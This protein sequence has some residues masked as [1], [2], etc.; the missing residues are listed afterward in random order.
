MKK[1]LLYLFVLLCTVFAL[2]LFSCN[3]DSSDDDDSTS[4]S[5]SQ[6]TITI[7]YNANGGKTTV[8]QTTQ[9]A[10]SGENT[11]LKT[12]SE[13][14]LSRIGHTFVGWSRKSDTAAKES[15]SIIA[16]GTFYAD[17]TL[18]AVW[19]EKVY[20]YRPTGSI[21]SRDD[22]EFVFD[23]ETISHR[24]AHGF[25]LHKNKVISS[26]EFDE[27]NSLLYMKPLYVEEGEEKIENAEEM[28]SFFQSYY[29]DDWT[30]DIKGAILQYY[31]N[32]FARTEIYK[33]TYDS[34]A[35]KYVLERYF[36][37]KLP[38]A[39][40][41]DDCLYDASSIHIELTKTGS[42]SYDIPY[43]GYVD[44]S[45]NTF[46]G[47]LYRRDNVSNLDKAILTAVGTIAGTYSTS[48]TGTSGCTV[49]LTFDTFPSGFEYISAGKTMALT[50][51][52][53]T[54]TLFTKK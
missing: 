45:G 26:Y 47:T 28:V 48:G 44:F 5:S 34:S 33:Y 46:S 43:K 53:T 40:L 2:N 17:T 41:F 23:E 13:L 22:E 4:S 12:A 31:K 27:D 3:S 38:S 35:D 7:T 29:K 42:T 6:T 25:F 36:D 20:Y 19:K 50:Q 8:S 37:G 15:S 24:Y 11:T 9:T 54:L 18:Y 14:G 1:D 30:D 16:D 39:V 51:T 52:E 32:W 21:T 49:S 10:N